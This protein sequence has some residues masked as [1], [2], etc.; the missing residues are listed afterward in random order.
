[1]IK[2]KERET[3]IQSLKSGVVPRLGLQH[4]QVG[5]SEELKSF[6]NDVTT[7]AEGGTSFR[8]VIGEY[9]SGKTFFLSLVRS[10]A[11]QKGLVTMNAD[12]SP[13]KRLHGTDGHARVLLSELISSISTRTKQDGNALPNILEKFIS[14]ARA[15][16]EQNSREVASVI[17]EQ[18][19]DLNEYPGGY[20]FAQVVNKYWTA[21]ESGDD[22]LKDRVLRWLKAEY[23]TKTDSLRDL[24]VREFINDASFFN[25]LK[26][27]SILVQKAGYSG[28]L[29]CMDEM[30]N[31]YKISNSVSR[32]ANY[33]EILNILNNTLQGTLSHIGFI[34]SGTPEFLTDGNRGLY[35]YEALKSRLAENSFSKSLGLTDYNSI[36]LRLANLTKEELYLLLM[37]LR[38]VFAGGDE[39]KYLVP[40][41]ALLA[42]LNH[43]ANKIGDSYFRTPRNTIKGFLDL[44]SMLEQYPDLKWS[45]MIEQ[46]EVVRDAESTE[47]GEIIAQQNESHNNIDD[48]AF[49][50][51]KL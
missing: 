13:T 27:Y 51:F 31:L 24:G 37:N 21:Y 22:M 2:P 25:T 41:D 29:V 50:S 10:I 5:R 49:A 35:S 46:I 3:I 19:S 38:N 48:D 32:K 4:I 47:V 30:V 43:C 17:Y 34:M 26:L 40:N 9:G 44:L 14:K 39:S 6:V 20:T 11:L 33:E 18:L 36:V 45:D 42:Y 7:I 8:F 12:L 28:L 1:M 15:E 16:A 23:S